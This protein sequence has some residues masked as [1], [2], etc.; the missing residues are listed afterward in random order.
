MA[1]VK[2]ENLGKK[3]SSKADFTIE[4]INIVGNEGEIVGILGHNGAGKSTTI[5]CITGMHPYEA[6]SIKIAGYDMKTQPIE[7]KKNFY[8]YIG[9]NNKI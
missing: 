3:Y 5:K 7:A 4:N 9:K 1:L 6:G 8:F 2:I